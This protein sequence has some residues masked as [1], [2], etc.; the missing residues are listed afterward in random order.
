MTPQEKVSLLSGKDFWMTNEIERLEV[1][2]MFLADGPHGMRKQQADS[3]HLG[4]NAGV[5]ATC[6]PT[7]ATIANSWSTDLG[8]EIG[9]YL[10]EEAVSMRVNMVLGPGL[11]IKRSP[12]CG[13][14]FE[15][16]SEDPYLSGKM[17]AAYVKGIQKNGIS[18]CPKHFA[19]NSQEIMRMASDSVM[20]ERT[21]RE[22]YLTGF[23][24]VVKEAKPKSIMS[25]YN[26]INGTYANENAHLL[27]E[28]LR[29]EWGYEGMVVSDWG[30]GNSRLDGLIAGSHLEMPG[31]GGDSDKQ[32]LAAFKEAKLTE[33]MLDRRVDEFLEVVFST[34][35]KID[36]PT[37]FDEEK[38]HQ[39][40]CKAAEESIVLLKN[41][42]NILPLPE[43]TKV[44]VIGDFAAKPRYQGAGSSQV[45]PT[46]LD[47]T[48]DC[49]NGSGLVLEGHEQGFLRNGDSSVELQKKACQLAKKAEV[50][51]L[52][53][54]L[55]EEEETEGID[56]THMKLAGNQI[57]LLKALAQ[58]N[59][60]I[61][62]ILSGGAAI[63]MPWVDECKAVVHGY[64]AGQAGAG[65]ILNV[66]TG[67]V[68]PSGKLAESYP[69]TLE[70]VSSSRYYPGKER[71]SE[72]REGIF[73]GYRY[74][75]TAKVPVR[76][77]FG[78]GLSYTSFAYSNLKMSNNEISFTIKNIGSRAGA[79]VAQVYISAPG[80]DIFVPEKELKGFA[81]VFLAPG[82]S[83]EVKV[84]LTETAFRYFN[85]ATNC[86]E[87][88]GGKY[89]VLVGA[90]SQDICL[91]GE[92]EVAGTGAKCPYIK[93]ALSTYYKGKVSNVPDKE[94]E[95]LLGH[96]IPEAKWDRT[97]P[98]GR[99]DT[100]AQLFYA[101]SF[102]ARL[103]YKVLN[104]RLVK[105]QKEGKTDITTLFL[106]YGPFRG[107]AKLSGGA[108]NLEMVD[109]VLEV[110]N[111][112]FF[113]GMSH[114]LSAKRR[115]EKRVEE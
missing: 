85:V 22:I 5:P 97:Q 55:S 112:H 77:P 78:F 70:D 29:D 42:E 89:Q 46:R 107:M 48:I 4:L 109:A 94:F 113:K 45:N 30:G 34:K 81:K 104:G 33:E 38:H 49:I 93:E 99:N 8:E 36:E 87:I 7:A 41:N 72:Y 79:E 92:L 18:A 37:T 115:K 82:E 62:V 68:N 54:G 108:F 67:K 76:F 56:R 11:N 1:P 103:V 51:L 50:V 31:T 15:Y 28:I 44:A 17:A 110:I 23:E 96:K 80:V 16:F 9:T 83:K 102:I 90:S 73:V 66:I 40:A 52:Y 25:S 64:L 114:L 39:I 106:F 27:Q 21:F 14:N 47:N 88:E 12:L 13:R 86:Y 19:A 101:K 69:F 43:G 60:N 91:Q 59:S 100:V 63:E 2:S 6:F 57:D 61:V 24:M 75:E 53:L 71:T 105:A 10:G 111:G 3:D 32:L 20:D 26:K 65:A 84:C 74:Y 58:E 98:L 95:I 35:I